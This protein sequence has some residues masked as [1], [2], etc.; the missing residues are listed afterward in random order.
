MHRIQ[1]GF[2]RSSS[3]FSSSPFSFTFSRSLSRS[4]SLSRSRSLSLKA[5][6]ES[7]LL[8][9]EKL[10]SLLSPEELSDLLSLSS[11]QRPRFLSLLVDRLHTKRKSQHENK[12]ELRSHVYTCSLYQRKYINTRKRQEINKLNCLYDTTFLCLKNDLCLNRA[13]AQETSFFCHRGFLT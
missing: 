6:S 3:S 13:T 10:R 12:S 8:M 1:A 11:S 9:A 4:L 5:S 2:S 7:L